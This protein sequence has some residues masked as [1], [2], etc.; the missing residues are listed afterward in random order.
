MKD[1]T[2]KVKENEASKVSIKTV[3]VDFNEMVKM[4]DKL[5]KGKINDPGNVSKLVLVGIINILVQHDVVEV[6]EAEVKGLKEEDKGNKNVGK[7]CKSFHYTG[8]ELC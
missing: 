1:T 3:K 4:H 8:S 7:N 2:D 5:Y 6:L